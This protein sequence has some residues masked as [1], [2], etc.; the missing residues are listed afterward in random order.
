MRLLLTWI[1]FLIVCFVYGLKDLNHR[2]V[3]K[4]E[5]APEAVYS[6]ELPELYHPDKRKKKWKEMSE[7][8]LVNELGIDK[9]LGTDGV[10]F[11][12]LLTRIRN[13]TFFKV[14]ID[15]VFN[16]VMDL[17]MALLENCSYIKVFVLCPDDQ[18]NTPKEKEAEQKKRSNQQDA[19]HSAMD[20][21]QLGCKTCK[22]LHDRSLHENGDGACVRIGCECKKYAGCTFYNQPMSDE[23]ILKKRKA[24]EDKELKALQEDPDK[25]TPYPENTIITDQG[26]KYYCTRRQCMITDQKFDFEKL[27]SNRSLRPKLWIFINDKVRRHLTIPQGKTFIFNFDKSGPFIHNYKFME[28]TPRHFHN[29][30]EADLAVVYFMWLFCKHVFYVLTIDTD[31]LAIIQAYIGIAPPEVKPKQ[32]YWICNRKKTDED[33]KESVAQLTVK[34]QIKYLDITDMN[35]VHKKMLQHTTLNT[36]QLIFYYILRGTDYVNGD[37]LTHWFNINEVLEAMRHCSD[38]ILPTINK[39]EKKKGILGEE[40][41]LRYFA[42]WLYT[43]LLHDYETARNQQDPTESKDK[44]D[45]QGEFN[46]IPMLTQTEINV[47]NEE[48]PKKKFTHIH[49]ITDPHLIETYRR[50]NLTDQLDPNPKPKPMSPVEKMISGYKGNQLAEPWTEKKINIVMHNA[51]MCGK[52]GN[53]K[54]Y[55]SDA[56]FKLLTDQINFQLS[57]WIKSWQKYTIAKPH[58]TEIVEN[59]IMKGLPELDGFTFD[60][61]E[62]VLMKD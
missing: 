47:I 41:A 24:A 50:L 6:Y 16:L 19:Y 8:E 62:S 49:K 35:R 46:D 34:K 12:D 53:Y 59:Y 57:Y 25:N 21:Y 14:T 18:S 27:I 23:D 38:K 44:N 36:T 11:D 29:H 10:I 20:K 17:P 22:H 3:I 54:D 5:I 31:T 40:A 33:D 42:R 37:L 1:Q 55:P 48:K 51:K 4:E 52:F 60:T 30:G 32:V 15:Y 13:V 45:F 9:T 7:E 39:G 56:D 28:F 43:L 58:P 61:V 26:L 2:T